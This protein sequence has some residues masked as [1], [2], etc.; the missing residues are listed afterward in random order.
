[1]TNCVVCSSPGPAF[2]AQKDG[3]IFDRC[4]HCGFIFLDPMPAQRE[5]NKQYTSPH[6]EAEPTY[7]KAG[8]RLRRAYGKLPRFLPYAWGR[9]IL[10]LGC[11]GGFVTHALGLLARSATGIDI[12]GNAI[13]YARSR[14]KRPRFFC[15]SFSEAPESGRQ[16]GFIYSSEVIEHVSDVNLYMR[17]LSRLAAPGAYVYI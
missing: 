9:D 5:L 12:S 10:D 8:S 7:D 1:M 4:R 17:T 3:Y 14:F 11:G 15:C 2:L 13:A 16:Y 6:R